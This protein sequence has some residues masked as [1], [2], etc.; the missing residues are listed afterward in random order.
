[1]LTNVYARSVKKERGF[2]LIELL[3]VITIIGILASVVLASLSSARA[4][5]RDAVRMSEMRQV[6]TA[7]EMF[8]NANN[9]LYPCRPTSSTGN[10]LASLTTTCSDIRPYLNS[11]PSDPVFSGASNYQ[12]AVTIDRR[13]YVLRVTRENGGACKIMSDGAPIGYY[14]NLTPSCF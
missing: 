2:T 1:M 11:I 3:V 12:Y 9:N 10:P 4:S 8:R 5:A 14:G 6:M 7:L 13:S